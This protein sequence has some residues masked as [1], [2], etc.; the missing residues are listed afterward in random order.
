MFL[1]LET[2]PETQLVGMCLRC[3]QN[4]NRTF[5]LWSG[6][7]PRRKEVVNALP[8]PIFSVQQFDKGFDVYHFTGDTVYNKWAALRVNDNNLVPAGMLPLT[9]AGGLYAVFLHKGT[10]QDFSK[11]LQFIYGEWMP[12]SGYMP[13]D[14]EHFELLGEKYRN[15]SPDSE[16]EVWIPVRRRN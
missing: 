2:L 11:T 3:S 8:G 10:T 15:N 14:R 4:Q 16:E 9:L 6:F 5:E 1:R 13:D 12:A 7:M